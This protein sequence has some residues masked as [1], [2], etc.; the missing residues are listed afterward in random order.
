VLRILSRAIAARGFIVRLLGI[1]SHSL[2]FPARLTGNTLTPG[3]QLIL[4]IP[5]SRLLGSGPAMRP[6]LRRAVGPGSFPREIMSDF[7]TSVQRLRRSTPSSVRPRFIYSKQNNCRCNI[8]WRYGLLTIVSRT[9]PGYLS[10]LAS[11]SLS[12]T[13][14]S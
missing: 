8:S 6:L 9:Q 13:Q 7:P 14:S 12:Y 5:Q 4:T 10:E 3:F 1:L 2:N 11:E